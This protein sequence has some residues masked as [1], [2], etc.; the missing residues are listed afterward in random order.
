MWKL[1]QV[2]VLLAQAMAAAV[3][4]DSF[5]EPRFPLRWQSAVAN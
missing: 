5:Q 2:L 4:P 1:A 3:E